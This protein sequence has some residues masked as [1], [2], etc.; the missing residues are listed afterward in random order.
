[1]DRISKMNHFSEKVASRYFKQMASGL[2]HC[3]EHGVVHRDLKPEN[4]LMADASPDAA[5]KITDFG[6]AA[7]IEK[8]DSVMKDACGS[9]F[10]IA[11]EMFGKTGFTCVR[12]GQAR[13]RRGRVHA[14]R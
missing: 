2:A 12:G 8:Q 1:M 4:F 7:A 5:I 9:A 6:L 13:A 3:H 10:Y 14:R 11:P